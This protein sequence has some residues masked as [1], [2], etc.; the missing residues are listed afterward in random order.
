MRLRR[1]LRPTL[2]RISS[3]LVSNRFV[4]SRSHCPVPAS[5]FDGGECAAKPILFLPAHDRDAKSMCDALS[6]PVSSM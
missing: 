3:G 4:S 1:H 2:L 5:S 6:C